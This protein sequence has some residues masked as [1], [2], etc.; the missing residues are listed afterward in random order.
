MG[1]AQ[2]GSSS[3]HGGRA[4]F[5]ARKRNLPTESSCCATLTSWMKTILW[6]ARFSPM[7]W[8]NWPTRQST[9]DWREGE[10]LPMEGARVEPG[11]S[12]GQNDQDFDPRSPER[13]LRREM[14]SAGSQ[15]ANRHRPCRLC[16]DPEALGSLSA[17][18]QIAATAGTDTTGS[19]GPTRSTP[20]RLVELR[21][22]T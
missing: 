2:D 5:V 13:N 3:P 22:V 18:A 10:K 12:H 6:P 4:G 14:C 19:A 16:A 20:P 1:S 8:W 21:Q 15:A 17:R 7:P 9:R 11:A